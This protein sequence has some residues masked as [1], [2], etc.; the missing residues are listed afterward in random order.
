M[1]GLQASDRDRCSRGSGF[2][3]LCPELDIASEGDSIEEART[4]LI[5]A[6]TLF[7]QVAD[8]T[9]VARRDKLALNLPGDAAAT[10]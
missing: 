9:E 10:E 3:A 1:P 5:E 7:F 8:S 4:N 6:L 2:I